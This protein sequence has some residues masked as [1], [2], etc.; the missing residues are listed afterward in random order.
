MIEF[1]LSGSFEYTQ[2]EITD[3]TFFICVE[4]KNKERVQTRWYSDPT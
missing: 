2:K 1:I 4:K 3:K